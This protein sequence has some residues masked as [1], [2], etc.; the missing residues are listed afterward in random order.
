MALVFWAAVPA[1]SGT[2]I[3]H[4]QA[5]V[6]K[7]GGRVLPEP[8]QMTN[9]LQFGGHG[10]PKEFSE[11]FGLLQRM[12]PD[13]VRLTTMAKE[14]GDPNAVSTGPDGVPAGMPGDT[15]DGLPLYL[16]ILTDFTVPD[17]EKKYVVLSFAHM[18]EPCGRE[19]VLASAQDLL[20]DATDGRQRLYTDGTGLTNVQHQATAATILRREKIYI[21][22]VS[23]DGWASGD[24]SGMA[25]SEYNGAGINSN[26][27][28]S[29]DGWS[30]YGT[31]LKDL[32]FSTATQSE[33]LAFTTYLAGVRRRELHG[34]PF[35]AGIDLH[36]PTPVATVLV[37]DQGNTPSKL[38]ATQDLA[39]RTTAAMDGVFET[40]VGPG[41]KALTVGG[42]QLIA[43]M[44][45]AGFN[46]YSQNF[47]GL[48]HPTWAS[49]GGIWD[50]IG[51]TGGS[52]W[53]GWMQSHSGLDAPTVTY[54]LNCATPALTLQSA[55][56]PFAPELMQLFV[57]NVRAV[58]R[59][60]LAR[61]LAP[62]EDGIQK[63]DLGGPVGY[64]DDGTRLTSRDNA[65]PPPTGFPELPLLTQVHQVPYA[66]S[67][68][69]YFADLGEELVS[70][71][72][73]KLTP[74]ALVPGLKNLKTLA[75]ADEVPDNAAVEEVVRWV[76]AG[77]NL[78]LTDSALKLL[79][80][81]GL[82]T[83]EDTVRDMGYVGYADLNLHDPLTSGLPET[84]RQTYDPIGLGYQ[85]LIERDGHYFEK[86]PQ[87]GCD[88]GTT[89]SAPIWSIN[90]N[91]LAAAGAPAVRVVGTVDPP[92][93]PKDTSEGYSAD[94]VSIGQYGLGRGRVTFFG[95][96]LPRPTDKNPHWYGLDDY[97]ISYA[98]QTMLLRALS[99]GTGAGGA[100]NAC[101]GRRRIK[102]HLE[103]RR[104]ERVRTVRATVNGRTL[105]VSR[106]AR[107]RGTVR[108]SIARR[109][110]RR[111]TV[112]ITV[113]TTRGRRLNVIRRYRT[114]P[115]RPAAPTPTVATPDAAGEALQSGTVDP[116]TGA[117]LPRRE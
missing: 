45:D 29:S 92:S 62:L 5:E 67:Q 39:A 75:L 104:G 113:R 95:A 64:Y 91:A 16:V 81:F 66:V 1:A 55:K 47:F 41:G 52:S 36:G 112:R 108:V 72:V 34:K 87:R 73:K 25:F 11:A 31:A 7:Y 88:S 111:Y 4:D 23:P 59:T 48:F 78:V 82:G 10:A 89:N 80:K 32:G 21:P 53:G 86:C 2:P 94:K 61:A 85:L 38:I 13:R 84:A 65:T 35:A 19:G 105:K 70:T 98:G 14:L 43:A 40:N 12:Y 103:L 3:A 109:P 37:H 63:V 79:P 57:D 54:E 8:R 9:Y 20:L 106:A 44:R 42:E 24:G 30:F 77:G 76:R 26:R 102:I 50:Q 83:P 101:A 96:L 71:P 33:G 115:S 17:T 116:T 117:L 58:V 46:P 93:D 18:A 90:R 114:C 107:R 27:I 15:G 99:V 51:Y 28:A 110:N 60:T 68:T 22:V 100:A 49:Y 74:R 69:N 97:A 6:A 56:T